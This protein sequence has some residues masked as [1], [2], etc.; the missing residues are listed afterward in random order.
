[1]FGAAISV[2]NKKSE[3]ELLYGL[4]KRMYKKPVIVVLLEVR[5]GGKNSSHPLIAHEFFFIGVCISF[6]KYVVNDKRRK[7]TFRVRFR[8]EP[9]CA[10]YYLQNLGLITGPV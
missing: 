3:Q 1:M 8:L 4:S 10:T 2:G 9:L 7:Q 5:T 6:S